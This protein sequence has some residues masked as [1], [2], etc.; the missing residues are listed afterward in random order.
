MRINNIEVDAV[1]KL[2]SEVEE[3]PDK[4]R[5][6]KKAR[7]EWVF[8]EGAPQFKIYVNYEGGKLELEADSPSKMGGSGL[9]PDPVQYCL[10]GLIACFAQTFVG[11]ATEKGVRLTKLKVTAE[12]RI[13]LRRPLGL[14][15]DPI[16]EGVK[17]TV[18]AEGAEKEVLEEI[19]KE[20]MYRCPGVYC[21]SNPVPVESELK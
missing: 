5:V 15:D 14:G 3:D 16:S 8:E 4:A 6:V 7:G 21:V 1:K 13:N 20:S 10:S 12:A 9:A 2:V 17:I 18:D 19:L 11:I